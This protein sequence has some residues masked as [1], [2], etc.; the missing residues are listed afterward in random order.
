MKLIISLFLLTLCYIPFAQES[1]LLGEIKLDEIQTEKDTNGVEQVVI[2]GMKYKKNGHYKDS[3][4]K[5]VLDY[6]HSGDLVMKTLYGGKKNQNS[7]V[8]KY[9]Y[10]LYGYVTSYDFQVTTKN[11]VNGQSNDFFYNTKHQVTKQ[12]ITL[13][14]IA[15]SYYPDGR[16]SKKMYYYN[17]RGETDTEPW[18]IL[19]EYD[20]NKNLIH[21]DT[22]TSG[23]IQT[24]FY[25]DKGQLIRHDYYPGVAYTTYK[26]DSTGNC[27]KQTDYELGKKDWDSTVYLFAYDTE[28]RLISS[29]SSDKRGKISKDQ[30]WV[31][32]SKGQLVMEVFY[33]RNKPKWINRYNYTYY[34]FKE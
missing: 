33:K 10:D 26:Y 13:A 16:I 15:Y 11:G 12:V 8:K 31:Y 32:N 29:S 22:D 34:P 7:Y 3:V 25:D 28:G 18:T 20:Q 6:S 19:F 14:T 17:N 30:E 9:Q 2:Y 23:N 5:G 24:S 21:A 27:I 1:L 4:V